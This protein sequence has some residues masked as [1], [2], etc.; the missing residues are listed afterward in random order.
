MTSI[1]FPDDE[2]K[3]ILS[4]FFALNDKAFLAVVE[5]LPHIGNSLSFREAVE[6]VRE[7]IKE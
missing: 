7:H 2:F 6:S 1:G 5:A 4:S 3:K